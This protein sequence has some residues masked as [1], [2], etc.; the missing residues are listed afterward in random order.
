MTRRRRLMGRAPLNAI[1]P[2]LAAPVDLHAEDIPRL[3]L[4]GVLTCHVLIDP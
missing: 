1:K 2:V 3:N 4:G